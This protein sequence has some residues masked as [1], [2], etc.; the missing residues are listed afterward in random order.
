MQPSKA[1]SSISLTVLGISISERRVQPKKAS[2]PITVISA[3]SANS[4]LSRPVQP[5]KVES[6]ISSMPA[7]IS[8][9]SRL[10]QAAKAESLIT[11]RVLGSSISSRPLQP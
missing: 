4:T 11:S 7:G 3:L 8:I 5:A 6:A 9:S 10:V 2:S 1:E